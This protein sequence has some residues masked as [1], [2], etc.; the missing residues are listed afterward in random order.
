[1][2][3]AAARPSTA[4]VITAR[5]VEKNSL[6]GFFDLRLASGLVLRSCSL[7]LSH[8]RWWVGTPATSYTNAD[9]AQKWNAVVDFADA[10]IRKRFQEIALAALVAY[11]AFPEIASST[12]ARP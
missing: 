12:E 1:M 7:H 10:R 6:R 9:G 2:K 4:V 3:S 8:A 5:R 11:G